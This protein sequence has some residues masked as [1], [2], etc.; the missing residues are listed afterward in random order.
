[1][2]TKKCLEIRGRIILT[3]YCLLPNGRMQYRCCDCEHREKQV[4]G[5]MAG[6]HPGMKQCDDCFFEKVDL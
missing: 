1:M 6:K 5:I 3:T 2:P 4:C